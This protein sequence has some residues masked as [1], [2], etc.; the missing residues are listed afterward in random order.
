[1]ATVT[2][3]VVLNLY[4][5]RF[6]VSRTHLFCKR[7]FNVKEIHWVWQEKVTFLS[8][9]HLNL[10]A[11]SRISKAIIR[12]AVAPSHKNKIKHRSVGQ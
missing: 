11:Y 8:K 2:Q 1:M 4:S 5:P 12:Q 6:L 10:R 9:R 3:H 7:K